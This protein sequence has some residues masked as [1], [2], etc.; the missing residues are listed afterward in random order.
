VASSSGSPTTSI[1]AAAASASTTSSW[2][3]RA[4]RTREVAAQFDGEIGVVEHDRG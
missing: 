4:T 1:P 2:R 3:E